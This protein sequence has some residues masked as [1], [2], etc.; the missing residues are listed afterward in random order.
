MY[1][2]VIKVVDTREKGRGIVSTHFI[3]TGTYVCEYAG[4]LL[5]AE[6]AKEREVEYENNNHIGCYMY[7]FQFKGEKYW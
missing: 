5:T 7:H 1:A 3:P 2:F 4:E 6:K